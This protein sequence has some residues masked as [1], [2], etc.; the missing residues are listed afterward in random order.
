MTKM[1]PM[2]GIAVRAPLIRAGMVLGAGLGGFA[3]GIL[4]HQVLQ[5]HHVLS[6]VSADPRLNQ[7]A[8]GLFHLGTLLLT[9]LGV[10]LLWRAL[11][12]PLVSRSPTVLAGALLAGFGLFNLIEG[13][14]DHHLLGLHHVRPGPDQMAWDIGYLVV[15]AVA[16]LL[17]WAIM[18]LA[19]R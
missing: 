12:D 6:A 14:V 8:D 4:L 19:R 5:W 17:G 11:R 10:W 2:R 3:D 18:R 15:G 16:A 9:A 7:F 1:Y 13:L